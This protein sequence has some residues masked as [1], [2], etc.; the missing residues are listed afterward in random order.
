VIG[1]IFLLIC[2]S[3]QTI[4]V[5]LSFWRG[6]GDEVKIFSLS[7]YSLMIKE[8]LQYNKIDQK[9]NRR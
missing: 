3:R 1:E 7:L 8:I 9:L 6:V 4:A 5:P 2:I